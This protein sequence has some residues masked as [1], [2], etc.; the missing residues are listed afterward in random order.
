MFLEV[1]DL[2][3]VG[4]W[5][6]PFEKYARQ[7]GNLPQIPGW[8]LKK[9]TTT[10]S[11]WVAEVGCISTKYLKPKLFDRSE[12]FR[13]WKYVFYTLQCLKPQK[14][15]AK[16]MKNKEQ[17]LWTMDMWQCWKGWVWKFCHL[18]Q[19]AKTISNVPL[20]AT[21]GAL[22]PIGSMGL[23]YSTV[24]TLITHWSNKNQAFM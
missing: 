1:A 12:A 16:T 6:N 18:C 11:S 2:Y 7:I 4:S 15:P 9:E 24:Y 22:L 13:A 3:L 19:W 17:H 14:A 21:H 8:T 20:K 23:V 10:Q 5:T